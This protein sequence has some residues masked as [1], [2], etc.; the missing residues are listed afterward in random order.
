MWPTR[1][2]NI[3]KNIIPEKTGTIK[4]PNKHIQLSQ[5]HYQ[6]GTLSNC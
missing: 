5:K 3:V 1:Q 6:I 2:Y 4:F